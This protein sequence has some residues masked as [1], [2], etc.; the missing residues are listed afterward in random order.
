MNCE[1]E[2]KRL[3][4]KQCRWVLMFSSCDLR[5]ISGTY[6][7]A[8]SLYVK[9]E[10]QR[11]EEL[12]PHAVGQLDS[13]KEIPVWVQGSGEEQIGQPAVVD[14]ESPAHIVGSSPLSTQPLQAAPLCV[15]HP[16]MLQHL[17]G[18]KMELNFST[19]LNP[20]KP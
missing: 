13:A 7:T 1:P 4:T 20:I 3:Q 12:L 6:E 14:I 18:K 9:C 8:Q 11:L 16:R 2:F 19:N 10:P 15:H 5:S 17:Q